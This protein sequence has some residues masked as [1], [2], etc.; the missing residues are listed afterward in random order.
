MNSLYET[1]KFN[2]VNNDNYVLKEGRYPLKYNEIIA[3]DNYKIGDIITLDASK[4]I[5]YEKTD[6]Y[7]KSLALQ[8]VGTIS[9]K[10]FINEDKY[11]LDYELLSSYLKGERLINNNIDLYSYFKWMETDNYKYVLYFDTIDTDV[12]MDN[13]I[14]Y[15]SSCY[16]YY[17]YL[18]KLNKDINLY[19]NYL[20]YFLIPICLYYFIKLIN[21]KIKTKEQEVLFLKANLLKEKQVIKLICKEQIL[22]NS[23]SFSL[24][25]LMINT[26]IL[27]VFKDNYID[28]FKTIL[29]Y[30]FLNI[31]SNILIRFVYKR[32]IKI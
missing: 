21:K 31:I 16:E 5:N 2:V 19:F 13:N 17:E 14:E 15:L 12:L 3:N 28:W 25:F 1:D 26:I 7:F 8:V 10:H 29:I 11:Y 23:I 32:R 22:L 6:L 4:I 18:G 27:L 9:S 24:S 20:N 30:L